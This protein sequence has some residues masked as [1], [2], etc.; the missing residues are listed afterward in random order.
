[1]EFISKSRKQSWNDGTQVQQ[2]ECEWEIVKKITKAS[3][4]TWIEI[5]LINGIHIEKP[6]TEL[7]W[8]N[9]SPATWVW[10]SQTKYS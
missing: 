4:A 7:K 8:R 6:K 10:I 1:M 5:T 9:P 3:P 2:L